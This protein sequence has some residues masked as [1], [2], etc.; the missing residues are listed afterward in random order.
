M[1]YAETE[2]GDRPTIELLVN[3]APLLTVATT[4]PGYTASDTYGAPNAV[5]SPPAKTAS[6][7]STPTAATK[8]EA[9]PA[10]AATAPGAPRSAASA[11]PSAAPTAAS[12]AAASAAATTSG[13]LHAGLE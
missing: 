6:C 7:A 3:G 13:E 2:A 10:T 9:Y 1:N 4:A 12:A 11:T 8:A 5:D